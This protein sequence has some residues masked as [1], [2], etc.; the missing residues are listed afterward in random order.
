M[1]IGFVLDD[2]LDVPDGV[3][4]YVLTLGAWL[5]TRG[6][7]VHYLVGQTVRTDIPN[8]HSLGRNVSVT[9][10][11]NRLSVPVGYSKQKLQQLLLEQHFDVLH[12]QM[13][14]S[15]QLAARIIAQAPKTTAVVGTFHILPYGH[16]QKAGAWML[17]KWV[18]TTLY[19][20]D[21]VAAVS[22]AAQAFAKRTMGIESVVIPNAVDLKKFAAG[23]KMSKYTDR[24]TIMFLGR[25]VPRKGAMQLVR[26]VHELVRQKRFGNARLVIVGHGSERS[27]LERYI[28]NHKLQ[29][30]IELVGWIIEQEKPN[31][32]ASADIAVFPSLAGESFGIVLV[33]AIAAGAG[34]VLGGDN[35]G[36][37]YVLEGQPEALVNPRNT[38]AFANR[39]ADLLE[40]SDLRRQLHAQQKTRIADFDVTKVGMQLEGVYQRAI[41]KRAQYRDNG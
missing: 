31:Y 38:A 41:A 35:P 14:Y 26:A 6:H 8:L 19:R 28:R 16:L 34:A 40:D 21:T 11:K 36:Y 9:F 17:S 18:R 13:P 25:L 2:G 15:P 32:L 24:P 5:S 29:D 1:N 39:I 33:E 27:R 4:Q 12:V 20:F 37:R 7:N 3:Q 22:S 30:H 23:K 10:N